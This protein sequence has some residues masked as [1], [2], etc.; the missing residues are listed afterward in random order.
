MH[1]PF[2]SRSLLPLCLINCHLEF[3]QFPFF[4]LFSLA[5]LDGR[6]KKKLKGISARARDSTNDNEGKSL[7]K[8]N[9]FFLP[10]SRVSFLE[11]RD[12]EILTQPIIILIPHILGII[13][14]LHL[15][16]S[17]SPLPLFKTPKIVPPRDC[18]ITAFYLSTM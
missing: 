10:I 16:F 9:I 18:E 14:E 2:Q 8:Q 5:N 17:P 11:R 1:E 12:S 6:R 3:P 4:S 13:S 15:S 7:M